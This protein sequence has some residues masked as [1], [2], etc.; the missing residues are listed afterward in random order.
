MTK[1]INSSNFRNNLKDAMRYVREDKQPLVITERGVPTSVLVDIDEFEDYLES[2]DGD[3]VRSIKQARDE[4][5][6]GELFGVEDVF[7][8]IV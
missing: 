4:K 6:R 7:G 1:T 5:N 8:S 3:F 2:R